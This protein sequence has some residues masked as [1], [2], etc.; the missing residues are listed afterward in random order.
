[1]L[2][3]IVSPPSQTCSGTYCIFNILQEYQ[4]IYPLRHG[5]EQQPNYSTALIVVVFYS[6][7]YIAW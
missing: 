2:A 5:T 1:M 6:L 3:A 7:F 4:L